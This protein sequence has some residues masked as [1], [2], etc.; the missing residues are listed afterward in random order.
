MISVLLACI[1]VNRVSAWYLWRPGE[2]DEAPRTAAMVVGFHVDAE[3]E[4]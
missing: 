3:K 2:A 4:T 1:Y